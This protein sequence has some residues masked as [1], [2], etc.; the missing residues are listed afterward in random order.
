MSWDPAQYGKF[1]DERS[2]PARDLLARVPLDA[3]GNIYDLGCGSGNI[4][5]LLAERWPDAAVCG[6]EN[7]PEMLASARQT[8]GSMDWTEGDLETWRT[9]RPADLLYAN[10]SLQWVGDHAALFPRLMGDLA[11]G[12]V[13]AVQM[14]RNYDAP[15]HRCMAEAAQAGPWRDILGKARPPKPVAAPE[16]YYDILEPHAARLDIWETEYL[17][18]L[19]GANPVVEWTRGT[20]LRPYL[21]ALEPEDREAFLVDYIGRIARAYPPNDDGR[22]LFPFRRL[23]IVALA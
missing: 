8:A 20:G 18:I 3:P 13:L 22:T 17:H 11:P 12:G 2:R 1:G 6:V 10:A 19:E 9:P 14:P 7:S 21:D 16:V 5:T 23:F 4:T 15:S